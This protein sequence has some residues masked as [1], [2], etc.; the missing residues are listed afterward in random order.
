MLKPKINRS[1]RLNLGLN[2][3]GDLEF[4]N[5][6]EAQINSFDAFKKEGFK[7]LFAEINPVKDTMEKM[8]T[9][10]FKDF[11]IGELYRT[12]DEAIKKGLFL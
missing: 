2:Y 10:E 8:W 3:S 9:L 5:L 7:N 4:P 6:I 11:R 1:G 12:V